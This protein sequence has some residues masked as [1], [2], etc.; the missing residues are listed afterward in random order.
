MFRPQ[1]PQGRN[2]RIED[3]R[4]AAHIAPFILK[5][6]IPLREAS[7]RRGVREGAQSD[8]SA[9]PFQVGA[10]A[11]SDDSARLLLHLL[12]P[13]R[14]RGPSTRLRLV[15]GPRSRALKALLLLL[16]LPA[17]AGEAGS[18]KA[19]RHKR[20]R[21]LPPPRSST[22]PLVG[23]L[24]GPPRGLVP[25]LRRKVA[26]FFLLSPPVLQLP[27]NHPPRSSLRSSLGGRVIGRELQD[28]RISGE[29]TSRK[30]EACFEAAA[31]RGERLIGSEASLRA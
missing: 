7:R 21:Y 9:R 13:A 17:G 4:S 2:K 8:D 19:G 30:R 11:L 22:R 26:S 29:R 1:A 18:S 14:A 10:R 16:C 5:R 25:E 23:P 31:P 6:E 28:P 3:K 15:L 20:C 12:K 27:P 24:R